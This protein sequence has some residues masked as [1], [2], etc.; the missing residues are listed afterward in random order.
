MRQVKF[1]FGIEGADLE[2]RRAFVLAG[3]PTTNTYEMRVEV[4]MSRYV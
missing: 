3:L 2:Q 1:A 4:L